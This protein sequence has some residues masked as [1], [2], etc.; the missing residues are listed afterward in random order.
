[1]R[2]LSVYLDTSVINFVFADDAPD[3]Q[4]A[5]VDFFEHYAE[6]YGLFISDVVLLEINRDPDIEHQSQLLSILGEHDISVL[7]DDDIDE[8]RQ[9]ARRYIE[10]GIIP[11]AKLEDALHVAHATVH[12]IDVL[13]SWN[14]RHLANVNKEAKIIAVNTEEG[15]RH[16]LRL[17]SPLEVLYES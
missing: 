10:Q 14:F 16:P 11:E 2:R 8:I 5:T 17:T 12:G 3:F 15:Y 6:L 1:M 7:P 9:L 13:L 4:R